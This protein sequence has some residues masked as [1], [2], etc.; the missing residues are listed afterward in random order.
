MSI[1][2]RDPQFRS[3]SILKASPRQSRSPRGPAS[4]GPSP[5]LGDADT[6]AIPA[7]S[8]SPRRSVEFSVDEDL[9]REIS[10]RYEDQSDGDRSVPVRLCF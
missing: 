4:H 8:P 7:E 3:P 5:G 9:V 1:V 6:L 2:G 10:A